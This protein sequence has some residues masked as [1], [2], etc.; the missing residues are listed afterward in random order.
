[1]HLSKM[2]IFWVP[3]ESEGP[4]IFLIREINT[5]WGISQLYYTIVN[6]TI[7]QPKL[8]RLCWSVVIWEVV[9]N[10]HKFNFLTMATYLLCVY[11][12][13]GFSGSGI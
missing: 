12:H 9:Q 1:M 11:D 13:S 3:I 2:Y 10:N 4:G 6:Y 8:C 7:V 5:M